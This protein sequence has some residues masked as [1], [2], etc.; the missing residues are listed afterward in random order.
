MI[1]WDAWDDCGITFGIRWLKGFEWELQAGNQK[2]IVG[3]HR[4]V[5]K[6]PGKYIPLLYSRGSLFWV[7]IK[8][9][10]LVGG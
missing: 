3:I 7:R 6:C 9:P 5:D 4:N 10:L 1:L 8:V 2:N